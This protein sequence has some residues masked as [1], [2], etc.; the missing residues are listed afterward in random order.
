MAGAG[1]PG[2]PYSQPPNAI[3]AGAIGVMPIGDEPLLTSWQTIISQFANSPRITAILENMFQYLDQ[4]QNWDN[5]LSYMLDIDTAVGYGL[6]VWGRILGVNRTVKLPSGPVYFGFQQ[7]TS[8]GEID[9]FGPRGQG[10]FY[11]GEPLTSSF[12]LPDSTFRQ[13]L[14]AKAMWNI[15]TCT[16]PAINALLMSL[17]G[18]PSQN[19][20]C[21]CKDNGGM[22]MVF[23]F[24]FNPTQTQLAIIFQTGILPKPV[25]VSATVTTP[26]GSSPY[27]PPV[28]D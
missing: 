17:F 23:F 7:G 14:L 8:G 11:A 3:G 6:D 26:S 20:L 13:L 1:P 15:T 12:A 19:Q 5:F 16:I 18:S 28:Y 9:T 21:W 25:G 27:N 2:P 22:A 24:N 4:T 10:P